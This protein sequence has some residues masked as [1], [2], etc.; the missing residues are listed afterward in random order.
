[1]KN[2]DTEKRSYEDEF[3]HCKDVVKTL[4]YF[5]S[6]QAPACHFLVVLFDDVA[7]QPNMAVHSNLNMPSVAK[8]LESLL[9]NI[10]KEMQSSAQ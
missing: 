10:Q 4:R 9:H 2:T 6:D 8:L 7:K 5:D 3:A 1:M